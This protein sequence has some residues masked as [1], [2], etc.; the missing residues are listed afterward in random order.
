MHDPWGTGPGFHML[1]AADKADYLSDEDSD[2][3]V[4]FDLEIPHLEEL[5]NEFEKDD[6]EIHKI[7]NSIQEKKR[8]AWVDHV[9]YDEINDVYDPR[10]DKVDRLNKNMESI[11][12]ILVWYGDILDLIIH[13]RL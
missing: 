12:K 10:Q 6:E 11:L 5:V 7:D 9:P 4:K 2:D 13:R 3:E 1:T 8:Q